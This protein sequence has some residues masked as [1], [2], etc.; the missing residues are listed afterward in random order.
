MSE[1]TP[2]EETQDDQQDRVQELTNSLARLQADYDNYRKRTE[3][4]REEHK[5]RATQHL[6]KDMLGIL[7]HLELALSQESASKEDFTQGVELVLSQLITILEDYGV[8]R[9]TT[10][11]FD[12]S[13]HEALLKE[14]SKQPKGTVLEV[15]QPGYILGGKVLRTAKVKVSQGPEE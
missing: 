10:E 15:L 6:I 3:R 5:K 9:I 13:L 1:N 14:H 2:Q 4:E 11:A 7:D 12:P 8:E